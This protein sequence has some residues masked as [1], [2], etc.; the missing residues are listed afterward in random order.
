MP[1]IYH[2]HN[3]TRHPVRASSNWNC[4]SSSSLNGIGSSSS[5]STSSTSTS[6]SS[7]S[8]RKSTPYKSPTSIKRTGSGAGAGERVVEGVINVSQLLRVLSKEHA[9][10][11]LDSQRYPTSSSAKVSPG[12]EGTE[13]GKRVYKR[14]VL[15]PEDTHYGRGK[16]SASTTPA[17]TTSTTT[18][19]TAIRG[20]SPRINSS[21]AP[22]A[23]TN[24]TMIRSRSQDHQHHH[25]HLHSQ[26]LSIPPSSSRSSPQSHVQMMNRSTSLGPSAT[27]SSFSIPST[28]APPLPSSSITS[29][30]LLPASAE[31]T[32][33]VINSPLARSFTSN[34]KGEIEEKLS[35]EGRRSR[36]PSTNS[37]VSP[38]ASPRSQ[39]SNTT[40][41]TTATVGAGGYGLS[42]MA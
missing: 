22:S 41:A 4:T 9:S 7:K 2:H 8:K 37:L 34:G 12:K 18:T 40:T 28:P 15:I 14:D 35:I 39:P 30:S 26:H 32:L 1:P 29:P 16:R 21:L 38:R 24:S 13:R 17:T 20:R 19:T 6:S 23:V 27:P 36:N 33:V 3:S 5:T 11:Q 10:N 31:S 42:V 25:H